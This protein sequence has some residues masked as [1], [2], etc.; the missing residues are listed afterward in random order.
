MVGYQLLLVNFFADGLSEMPPAK[1]DVK[2]LVLML[3]QKMSRAQFFHSILIFSVAFA[4]EPLVI[5]ATAGAAAPDWG[6]ERKYIIAQIQRW[7]K[8]RKILHFINPLWWLGFALS[9]FYC[10]VKSLKLYPL[11]FR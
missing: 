8:G 4:Y 10:L 1:K 11:I 5:F 3:R 6:Y 7:Q 9:V 2:L